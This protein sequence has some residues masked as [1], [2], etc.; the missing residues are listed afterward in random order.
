MLIDIFNLPRPVLALVNIEGRLSIA[1]DV[2]F[3]VVID[4]DRLSPSRDFI[5]LDQRTQ[6]TD[7]HAWLPVDS[8]KVIEVLC[9]CTP[10]GVPLPIDEKG[11]AKDP[12]KMYHKRGGN[13]TAAAA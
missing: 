13:K 10:A 8:V 9:E 2:L 7:V 3:Q 1:P 4:P 12:Q 5:H 6:K 11:Q